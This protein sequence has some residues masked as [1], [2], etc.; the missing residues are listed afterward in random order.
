MNL[1]EKINNISQTSNLPKLS[2][3]IAHNLEEFWI[4]FIEPNLP[5]ETTVIG[6]HNI[7]IKYIND[8]PV[9]SLRIYGSYSG[10]NNDPT[11]LRRGFIN[12]TNCNFN[13][14]YVD[15]FFTSYF[16]AMAYDNYVPNYDEFKTMMD[17]RRFP[18]GYMSTKE[19]NKYRSYVTGKDPRIQSKGYKIAHIYDAGRHFNFDDNMNTIGKFCKLYFPLGE[20]NDWKDCKTDKHGT[21]HYR[22]IHIEPSDKERVHKFLVAHFLRTVHPINYFLVPKKGH[23]S[24]QDNGV[25]KDEIGEYYP[26]INFVKSKIKQK[27]I[28]I[29]DQ[30][31]NLIAPLND[32]Q[33]DITDININIEYWF[34]EKTNMKNISNNNKQKTITA[35]DLSIHNYSSLKIGQIVKNYL[36]PTLQS[37]QISAAEIKKLLDADYSKQVFDI[38]YPLLS[39]ER[40]VKDYPRYYVNSILID[41]ITYYVCQEW[42]EKS[43]KKL[44]TWLKGHNITIKD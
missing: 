21:Y 27:Y 28:S 26:L 30:Y 39:K 34:N 14:V 8:N 16:Y 36:I 31:L 41:D 37:N 11:T 22:N 29:Y 13:T 12:L 4:N 10:K 17:S 5:K 33:S 15:N 25:I 6:W 20:Y 23:I 38:N 40:I 42:Y 9:F 7:F 1:Q 19:E 18:V 35:P 43:R 2:Q 24:F 44:E 3:G 32:K